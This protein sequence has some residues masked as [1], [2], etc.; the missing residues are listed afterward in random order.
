MMYKKFK[1]VTIIHGHS[2]VYLLSYGLLSCWEWDGTAGGWGWWGWGGWRGWE[3]F[4]RHAWC[5][6][7]RHVQDGGAHHTAHDHHLG[8]GS[9]S[10]LS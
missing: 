8:K 3:W 7:I 6:W 9:S 5:R 4:L 2:C 1:R 10:R